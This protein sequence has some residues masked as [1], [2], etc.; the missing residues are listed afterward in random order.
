[1]RIRET[2]QANRVTAKGL[3]ATLLNCTAFNHDCTEQK[4]MLLSTHRA[5]LEGAKDL[6][7]VFNIISLVYA[8]FLNYDIFQFIVNAYKI[9]H[10]QEEFK[11]PEQLKAYIEKHN[12]SEFMEINP[13]LKEIPAYSSELILKVNIEDTSE[14]S[15]IKDLHSA[16]AKIL[17]LRDA[18]LQLR[19]ISKGCVVV[20]FLIPTHISEIVFN[21][22]TVFTEKQVQMFQ[23]ES[24]LTLTCNDFT[25][26]LVGDVSNDTTEYENRKS[27]QKEQV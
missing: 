15:K 27:E 2:L 10:G 14:L 4:R 18:T 17:N 11:Y 6:C 1:M 12:V 3:S 26:S 25:F 16:I 13:Q 8:S 19:N 22:Q 5:E 21:K 9:D 7:E 24:I 20:T 23:A